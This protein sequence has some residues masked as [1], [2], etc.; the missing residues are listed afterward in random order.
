MLL[1]SRAGTFFLIHSNRPLHS[2]IVSIFVGGAIVDKGETQD[3]GTEGD[4]NG[5]LLAS[6]WSAECTPRRS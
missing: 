1:F 5:G 2:M 3:L 6:G 4:S